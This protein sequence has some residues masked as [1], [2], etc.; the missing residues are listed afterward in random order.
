ML[1]ILY[2][3]LLLC[4]LALFYKFIYDKWKTS[5]LSLGVGEGVVLSLAWVINVYCMRSGASNVLAITSWRLLFFITHDCS[6]LVTSLIW[7]C[8]VLSGICHRILC[9][10]Q[11]RLLLLLVFTNINFNLRF[12]WSEGEISVSCEI[13][14]LF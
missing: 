3:Y 9:N 5:L 13:K 8:F 11:H 2:Y 10:V 14:F 12:N 1:F 6:K 7:I 4:S